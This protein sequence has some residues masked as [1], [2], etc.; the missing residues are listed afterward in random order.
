MLVVK[1]ACAFCICGS[2]AS[3]PCRASKQSIVYR[4]SKNHAR[5]LQDSPDLRTMRHGCGDRSPLLIPHAKR[6]SLPAHIG[7]GA[8]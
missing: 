8:L 6:T 7:A 5:K 3:H 1:L 4:Q 2:T